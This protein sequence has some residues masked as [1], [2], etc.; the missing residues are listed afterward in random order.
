MRKLLA[1]CL[2]VVA[3][4]VMA[5]GA[6]I[7]FGYR[8]ARPLI[9]DAAGWVRQARELSAASAALT[10]TAPYTAPDSGELSD[11]QVRR[12]LAVHARVRESLGPRW[13]QLRARAGAFEER[14]PAG[15]RDLSLSE[16]GALLSEVGNLAVDAR[17]AHVAAL[18]AEGFSAAEYAWVRL[19]VYEA[20]GLEVA[21]TIDWSAMEAMLKRG[22]GETGAAVPEVSLP[23][24]PARNRVLVKPHTDE[25]REWLPLTMLGF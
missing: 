20:A 1:G 5:L 4:A 13:S 23:E 15:G 12:F 8:A 9:D 25:L 19:R 11:D 21:S 17:R 24:V 14:S 10:N 3:A 6:A 2:I 7:F 16:V 18:N 22:T